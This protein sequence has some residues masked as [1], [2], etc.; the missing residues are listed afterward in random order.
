MAVRPIMVSIV[1]HKFLVAV[2]FGAGILIVVCNAGCLRGESKTKLEPKGCYFRKKIYP[3]NS[4][5]RTKDCMDCTCDSHGNYE[6]CTIYGTP[7]NYDKERCKFV[8][9][10]KECVY[11]L[12]PNK[13]PTKQCET[14]G[15]VG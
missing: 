13:D 11:K 5:W 8:F 14:Y 4:H 12:I 10:K 1:G 3:L 2:A 9:D 15:M 7:G 6:C